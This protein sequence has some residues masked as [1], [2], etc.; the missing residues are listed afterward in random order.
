MP[1]AIKGIELRTGRNGLLHATRVDTR[2]CCRK[3]DGRV[4]VSPANH[5][6]CEEIVTDDV[7]DPPSCH[8]EMLTLRDLACDLKLSIN[9]SLVYLNLWQLSCVRNG[10]LIAQACL[11]TVYITSLYCIY[12]LPIQLF[13]HSG[14]CLLQSVSCCET[15]KQR[16]P[17]LV[18]FEP[19]Y[20]IKKVVF[21]KAACIYRV[22]SYGNGEVRT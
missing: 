9:L 15:A 8:E 6:C 3:C 22:S 21:N 19:L 1:R 18:F 12:N 17:A 2:W 5:D 10:M 4:Q 20:D 14:L 16:L 13:K 11:N 7:S